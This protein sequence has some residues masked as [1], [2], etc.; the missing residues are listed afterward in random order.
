MLEPNVRDYQG[1]R[2]P[3]NAQIRETLND[4]SAKEEFWWLNNG[5]TILG[6]KC[7]ISGNR[8]SVTTP[9]IVNGLQT[10]HEIFA[11]F[12]VSPWVDTRN[13]LVRIILPTEEQ[14]RNRIIKATNSQTPVDTLSLRAT[15]RIHLDIEDRLK[16]YG[17]YYDRRKGE[18]RRLR[19]AISKIVSVRQLA[20]ACMAILLQRPNDARARPSTVLKNDTQYSVLF[21]ESNNRDL[22]AACILL[23]RQ[24]DAFLSRIG[25]RHEV[26]RDIRYYV[27]MAVSCELTGRAKPTALQL[28]AAVQKCVLPIPED[29][30]VTIKDEV[31]IIY[32]TLGADD[33]VA[34]GTKLRSILLEA[35]EKRFVAA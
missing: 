20:Q 8:L 25:L 34:K 1:K 24:V 2:N 5:I 14:S 30:L 19:K 12:G 4:K 11:V 3:V 10:S 6:E 9:E 31:I 28:A 18:Y 16:A 22:Y 13:V 17:L 27:D 35:I 23:D 15:D 33:N 29:L 7:S 26:R 32:E 21:D